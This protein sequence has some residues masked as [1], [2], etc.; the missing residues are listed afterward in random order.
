VVVSLAGWW[1]KKMT[2]LMMTA[3]L[4]IIRGIKESYNPNRVEVIELWEAEKSS[5]SVESSCR[6][7]ATPGN[8]T[9]PS[10]S[11]DKKYEGISLK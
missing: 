1:A 5:L 11:I 2:I 6:Y 10:Q 7:V 3:S 8:V 9:P 4:L